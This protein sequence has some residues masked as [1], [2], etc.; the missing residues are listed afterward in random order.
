MSRWIEGKVVA[1]RRR[2]EKLFSL[3]VEAEPIAFEAGQFTK[4]ALPLQDGMLA[5]PY[6]FVNAPQ[7][8]PHEFYYGLVP[9]GPLSPRLARL[10][11]GDSVWLAAYP[12]GFLVLSEVPDAEQLWLIATGTGIG[13]FLSILKTQT[14]WGRFKRVALVHG[15]RES[16]DLAY[17][18]TIETL[19]ARHSPQLSTVFFVSREAHSGA[20]DGRI[21]RAIED[22]R[23][24]QA[25]G[26]TLR[27]ANSQVMLCGNPAMTEEVTRVLGER[28]MKKHRRRAPGHITMENYW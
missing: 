5:R 26:M 23:L 12:A 15:V 25:A 4:L 19:G 16:R 11:A 24:E 2:A 21:P 10:E 6:S 28:G 7:E 18:D 3:Q 13:P 22:G 14:P 1:Q 17:R 27:P 8:R 20:L 9:D